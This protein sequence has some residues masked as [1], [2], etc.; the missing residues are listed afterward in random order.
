MEPISATVI[1][2]DEERNIEAALQ[3]LSWANEIVVV[4]SGSTDGTLEICR[5]YTDRI[6]H[7][8]W[9]G[10]VDQKNFA[11]EN[12]RNPWIFSL[13]ADERVSPEL[14]DEILR[15]ADRGFSRSGYRVPRMAFFMGRWIRHGEWYPD[16][17]LRLFDRTKGKWEGGN[18]H[19]SVKI[20]GAPGFLKGNIHHFTY[21]NLSDYLR[22]LEI[23]SN[24]AAVDYKQRGKRA[25]ARTLLFNPTAAFFKAFVM[26]RGFL[27]GTPGFAV[28][29]MGAVSVFFKYAKLY[30]LTKATHGKDS[31]FMQS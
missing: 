1:A 28:A 23:Y 5:R 11:V 30:E 29:V 27:D 12:A 17:Q 10:Y 9:T 19:E 25:T 21:H 13:D 8:D 2:C 15:L 18:V 4:D 16:F 20:I 31:G 6:L 7:R 3:S 14:R 24:L 26:K 22:R